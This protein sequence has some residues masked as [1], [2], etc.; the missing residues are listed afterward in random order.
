[1][2]FVGAILVRIRLH[3]DIFKSPLALR[4]PICLSSVCFSCLWHPLSSEKALAQSQVCPH[5]WA[6]KLQNADRE[7]IKGDYWIRKY[8]CLFSPSFQ[9]CRSLWVSHEEP[10]LLF[11][12]KTTW[13]MSGGSVWWRDKCRKWHIIFCLGMLPKHRRNVMRAVGVSSLK[14]LWEE[15][16]KAWISLALFLRCHPQEKWAH[17]KSPWQ[18]GV[19]KRQTAHS[20]CHFMGCYFTPCCGEE[21][22]KIVAL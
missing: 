22:S 5:C 8:N 18:L 11:Y 3:T 10:I 12:M 19:L 9:S 6:I 21:G 7:H 13:P 15:F 1:M 2:L 17:R 14:L 20:R 16:T 4:L